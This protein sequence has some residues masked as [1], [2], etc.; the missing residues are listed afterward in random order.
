MEIAISICIAVVLLGWAICITVANCTDT[1]TT[2]DRLRASNEEDRI[3][4][5]RDKWQ[6]AR[7]DKRISRSKRK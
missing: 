2:P 6:A 5:E 1:I 3:I 4:L 7:E